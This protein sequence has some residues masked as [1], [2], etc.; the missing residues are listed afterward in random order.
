MV[1]SSCYL[2]LNAA[3]VAHVFLCCDHSLPTSYHGIFTAVVQN[4]LTRYFQERLGRTTLIKDVT[5]FCTLPSNIRASFSHLCQL[6]FNG[7]KDNKLTFAVSDLTA[8]SIPKDIS[9]TGLLQNVTSMASDGRQSY[10]CFLHLSIQELLAAVHIS[11]MS[12]K[13]QISVFQELFGNPRFSALLQFYAGITKLR[14]N[15][16]F[17]SLLPRFLRGQVPT[18]VYDLVRDI[19]RDSEH[20]K[21][22]LV[23]LLHCLYEAEDPQL[24]R[25]VDNLLDYSLNFGC[26]T[27]KPLDCLAI[28]YFSSVVTTT[29]TVNRCTVNLFGCSIGD[30]GCKFLVRG[31]CKCLNAQSKI[32]SQLNLYLGDNDIHEEGIHHIAQLLQNTSVVRELYLTGNPTGDSGLKRLCEAL[33][34]NTTLEELALS[35]C[36]I[37]SGPLLGQ[38]LSEN[39][40]LHHLDLAGNEITDWR[41]I[42][43]GL[44]KNRTLKELLLSNCGLTDKCLED[45]STGLNNYIQFLDIV[46]ND[47]ITEDGLNILVRRLTTL[48]GM[49]LLEIP[50]HLVSSIT[51]VLNEVNEE[52][53]RNK[54]PE[55]MLRGGCNCSFIYQLVM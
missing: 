35:Y 31:L 37:N 36:S 25:F 52:R 28:G 49:R 43:A 12:A 19:V 46:C 40:S 23:T 42:A 34:S 5:S 55:I 27:L 18:S 13:Q 6:A 1:E 24:C 7:I 41:S 14:T 51:P 44:S 4:T 33:S 26:T 47:S 3:I 2:P 10:F 11:H 9:K 32:T 20:S 39:D 30:Q 38:L 54:L 15:R 48:S 21:T 50:P 17:L 16:P 45:L 29:C 22:L 53:R 8:L